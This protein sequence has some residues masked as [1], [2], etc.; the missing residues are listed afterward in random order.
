MGCRG[1]LQK[2]FHAEEL[3]QKIREILS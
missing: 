2:P 3:S 1:F